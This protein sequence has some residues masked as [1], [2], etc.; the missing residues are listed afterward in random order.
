[1]TTSAD[2]DRLLRE[3]EASRKLKLFSGNKKY[4][5][6]SEKSGSVVEERGKVD[7]V[8]QFKN[9]TTKMDSASATAATST[10]A[11]LAKSATNVSIA[12]PLTVSQSA[13]VSSV[14]SKS[15]RLAQK[16]ASSSK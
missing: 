8:K 4:Q 13:G 9:K 16:P 6:A 14:G 7:A 11:A 12:K 3:F 5:T 10:V 2:S 15:C 1:V